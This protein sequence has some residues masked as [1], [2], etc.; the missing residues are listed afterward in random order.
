LK[1]EEIDIWK[2]I[3]V[4]YRI[5]MKKCIEKNMNKN[6]TNS[7]LI[8]KKDEESKDIRPDVKDI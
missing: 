4:G 5:K 7:N 2:D 1:D 6:T 3:P 8:L